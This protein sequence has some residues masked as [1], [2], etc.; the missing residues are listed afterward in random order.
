MWGRQ[1]VLRL[2]L[3]LPAVL[4]R[5]FADSES[6][7]KKKKTGILCWI[8]PAPCCRSTATS[9]DWWPFSKSRS[10]SAGGRIKGKGDETHAKRADPTS[11]TVAELL[12]KGTGGS[13]GLQC[14]VGDFTD[15]KG[16]ISWFR[17][18]SAWRV[19]T[20]SSWQGGGG[21]HTL[22]PHSV[23]KLPRVHVRVHQMEML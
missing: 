3:V 13:L 20:S 19:M 17:L 21:H 12:W 11:D 7:K 14:S 1:R 2:I 5:T 4:A 22:H 8:F 9:S 18:Q 16:R 10:G 23:V 15:S 6:K